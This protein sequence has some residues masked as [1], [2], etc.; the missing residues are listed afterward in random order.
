MFHVSNFMV[1]SKWRVSGGKM[2]SGE[3]LEKTSNYP[4]EGEDV[5]PCEGDAWRRGRQS[6]TGLWLPRR[7]QQTGSKATEPS[8]ITRSVTI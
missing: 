3:T 4:E 6:K 1:E 8:I 2:I 5:M 7:Q